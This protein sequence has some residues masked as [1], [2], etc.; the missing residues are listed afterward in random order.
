[1]TASRRDRCALVEQLAELPQLVECP[2]SVLRD[3]A[4]VGTPVRIPDGWPIIA[5]TTPGDTCYL[6]LVGTATVT[7]NG[8]LIAEVGAGNLIGEAGPIEARLRTATVCARGDLSVLRI[9]FDDLWPLLIRRPVLAEALLV[10]YRA[11]LAT[12]SVTR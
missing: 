11:R 5:E 10:D 3:L 1:M 7:R 12:M 4:S 2:L 6:V 8:R 9:A